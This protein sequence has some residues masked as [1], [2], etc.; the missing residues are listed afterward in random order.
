MKT[1]HCDSCGALVYFEN[2]S[3]V[4]CGHAL[5][6]LPDIMDLAALKPAEGDL[7]ISL[8]EASAGRRFRP[9]ANGTNHGVCN[10]FLPAEDSHDLCEACRLNAIV[11]DLSVTANV[12]LWHKVEVAKRRLIYGLRKL[13]LPIDGSE[14]RMWPR[15]QFRFLIESLG[16][17]PVLTGH[18]SGVITLN[19]SEADDLEREKIRTQLHEPQ[20]TLVGHFRHESG[21]YYWDALVA[22]SPF[23]ERFRA[24]FGDE[25]QDY[26]A[27]LQNH[28][29]S[30]SATDW[31]E[32]CVS[33]YASSHPWE[34]WAESWA[35]YLQM[36]DSLET[37][38]SFGMS[39]RPR[40]PAART[41]SAEPRRALAD[42][43]NFDTLLEN[44]LPLT[45]ALN[46]INR[47]TGLLD[48]YPY[49]LP[50]PALEKLR[51]VHDVI[52]Q[53]GSGFQQAKEDLIQRNGVNGLSR[54]TF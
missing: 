48:L 45:Y 14:E 12:R 36:V 47:G 44:W 43:A 42:G 13:A 9:C 31:P 32:R 26:A 3:C 15:L 51:L 41:I 30:G 52:A 22:N 8:A 18:E 7:W 29:N 50:P 6:F 23:H 53:A 49:L 5:G 21:H 39:L 24:L 33:A 16:S 34:D 35:H 2:V 38:A 37:A 20:R 54:A 25:R 1:F 11:P 46:S 27:A 28:Y 19:V 17:A 40:H 10:W 4:Q